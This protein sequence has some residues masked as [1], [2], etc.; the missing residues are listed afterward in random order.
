V[1]YDDN[2]D[3]EDND[4]QYQE[5]QDD[6]QRKNSKNMNRLTQMRSTI[7]LKMQARMTIQPYMRKKHKK[8]HSKYNTMKKI[9]T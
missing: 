8:N 4:E 3:E 9:P 5:E 7:S 6:N 2:N 1:D